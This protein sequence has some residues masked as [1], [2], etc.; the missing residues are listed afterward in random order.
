MSECKDSHGENTSAAGRVIF[1][2]R[3]YLVLFDKEIW[4]FEMENYCIRGRNN[5][6]NGTFQKGMLQWTRSYI[7]Q[8]K[9]FEALVRWFYIWRS[10]EPMNHWPT[11]RKNDDTTVDTSMNYGLASFSSWFKSI[12]NPKMGLQGLKAHNEYCLLSKVNTSNGQRQA[13]QQL[14][15]PRA[16][17]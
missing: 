13:G 12:C 11:I 2:R 8:W 5:L 3:G 16:S 15:P 7:L 9:V 17:P 4:K 6:R 10:L 14:S 1:N